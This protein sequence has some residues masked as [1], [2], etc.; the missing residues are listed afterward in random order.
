VK[1]RSHKQGSQVIVYDA[2]HIQQPGRDLFDPG[3]WRRAGAVAGQAPGRGSA[4]LL[5]TPFGPAVLRQYLRGG[6]PARLSRDRY[7]FTGFDRSRP[8]REFR[9]LAA[10]TADGLPVPEPL[11]ALC[12]RRGPWYRG[13]L[14]T[15]RIPDVSP[16]ADRLA[17]G[18]ADSALWHRTGRVIRRFHDAG[19][20]HADLNARN[21]L[22]GADDSVHLVDFDRARIST[23]N[24][25]A[26]AGNLMRLKRSLEKFWPAADRDRFDRCWSDLV[27]GYGAR[28][29]AG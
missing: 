11:A 13:W 14:M 26:F 10:L 1:A 23:G 3:H 28:A 15:R 27:S 12:E 24:A 5:E 8:L 29:E 21:I 4:L 7:W 22:L 18:S 16:L 25:R 19:I 17:G 9:M 2:D 6:W 20:V